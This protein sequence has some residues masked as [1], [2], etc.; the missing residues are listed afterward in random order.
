MMEIILKDGKE[1]FYSIVMDQAIK[2]LGKIQ[3]YIKTNNFTLEVITLL[4]S[5]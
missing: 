3:F 5:N 2:E 4:F 1:F